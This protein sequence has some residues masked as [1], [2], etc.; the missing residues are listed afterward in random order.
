M[1]EIKK[2]IQ[3]AYILELLNVKN[4][5]EG[6]KIISTTLSFLAYLKPGESLEYS[7]GR[8]TKLSHD[9]IHFDN[10]MSSEEIFDSLEKRKVIKIPI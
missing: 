6:K 10:N 8:F 3:P 2:T 4:I 5:E 7:S 9:L 1:K